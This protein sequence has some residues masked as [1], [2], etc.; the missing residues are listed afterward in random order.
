MAVT[1]AVIQLDTEDYELL[2]EYGR[3]VGLRPTTAARMLILKGLEPYREEQAKQAPPA[4]RGRVR[5]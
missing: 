1:R 2:T 4:R 3:T 5:S